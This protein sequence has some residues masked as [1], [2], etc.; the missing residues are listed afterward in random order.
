MRFES[1]VGGTYA[2]WSSN[3]AAE[4]SINL[5][6][7]VR[8][9]PG[10]KSRVALY[11]TPGLQEFTVL[12]TAPVRGLWAGEGRLFAVASNVLYEVFLDGTFTARGEVGSDG[13]LHSPVTFAAN[14]IQLIVV[15]A[16]QI[17]LDSGAGPIVV[18]PV[19]ADD[20]AP[21]GSDA[22]TVGTARSAVFLDG[23]FIAS[24]PDSKRFFFSD[25]YDGATWDALEVSQKE[26]YPDNIQALYADHEEL[27]LFGSSFSTE[28]WRNEGDPNTAGGFRRDPGGFIHVACVAPWSIVSMAS[29]L[30]F[31]GGD[32]RGRIIAYRCQGFQPVRVSTHAVEQVWSEYTD[33]ARAYAYT[34][35]EEGHQFWVINFQT[36]N[37]TWVYDLASQM[38]HERAWWNGSSFERHRGRCHAFVFGKHLVG[39]HTTGQIFHMSHEFFDDDGTP[40][41]RVRQAP[42]IS[43]E[44]NRVFSHN[45]QLDLDITGSA[46]ACALDW[47]DDDGATFTTPRNRA[48]SIS[49][50]KRGRVIWRRLGSSRDRIYRVT[51][52]DPVK[53]AIADAFLTAT[54][55]TS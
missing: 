53:V 46:P 44:R 1:F 16:D 7:S 10:G 40:I 20:S 24:K 34:Y 18:P 41:R 43:A 15:S 38:W 35:T 55:G 30:H 2:E 39:D 49:G 21:P 31:L 33:P 19:P 48:P 9:V 50:A 8:E 14:G 13:P 47:S 5:F 11:S 23:Y 25:L 26:G 42:H 54:P 4:R 36:D 6:P 29:G 28:V 12:P 32:T 22:N 17:W 45:L 3:F 37:A 27:W 51:I 52:S